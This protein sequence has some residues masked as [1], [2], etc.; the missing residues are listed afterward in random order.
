NY[1]R[2]KNS[3]MD[4][5]LE[6]ASSETDEAKLKEL[7]YKMQDILAKDYVFLPMYN[8]SGHVPYY[9]GTNFTGWTEYE[10]PIKSVMNL[11][12]LAPTK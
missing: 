1:F 7:Y 10:A 4:G 2:Y 8:S 9:D 11:I 12:N 6:Q 3:E 5:L